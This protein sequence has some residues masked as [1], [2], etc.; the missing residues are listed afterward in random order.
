MVCVDVDNKDHRSGI[1][2]PPMEFVG[3]TFL[4]NVKAVTTENGECRRMNEYLYLSAHTVQSVHCARQ[5][6]WQCV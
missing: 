6:H 1:S 3:K 5:D 2:S 4:D